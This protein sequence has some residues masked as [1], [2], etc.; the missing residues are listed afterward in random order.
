ML[1]RAL[2]KNKTIMCLILQVKL[3]EVYKEIITYM[4]PIFHL[5][6]HFTN[7][8]L[9]RSLTN[10]ESLTCLTIMKIMANPLM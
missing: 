6:K 2:I 8:G 1:Y 9:Q 7:I 10:K 5:S 3:L 4:Q